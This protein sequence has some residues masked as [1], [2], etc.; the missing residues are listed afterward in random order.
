V[1]VVAAAAA[2]GKLAPPSRPSQL[3]SP[4]KSGHHEQEAY[5]RDS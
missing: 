4:D 3:R 5:S 2:A 1:V